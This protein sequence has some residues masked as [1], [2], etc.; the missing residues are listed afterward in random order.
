MLHSM[1]SLPRLNLDLNVNMCLSFTGDSFGFFAWP[2]F[3]IKY[4]ATE[5]SDDLFFIADSEMSHTEHH[6]HHRPTTVEPKPGGTI[7]S[8]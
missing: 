3:G 1:F 8:E 4:S 2:D 7:P 6:H 5:H